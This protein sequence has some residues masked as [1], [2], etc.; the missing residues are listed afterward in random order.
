MIKSNCPFCGKLTKQHRNK[1]GKGYCNEKCHAEHTHQLFIE[2]WLR[3]D[4]E[5]TRGKKSTSAHIKRYIQERDG[6][7]CT[8]C[9]IG[10]IWN[11][12]P[13]TIEI[14]HIDGD[15]RNNRPENLRCICPNCHTQTANYGAR[16]M[17]NSTRDYS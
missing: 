5:G 11:G 12:K 15:Y 14:D 16:N 7:K 17:G 6:D 8:V 13:L 9:G 10:N 2:S 3:G 1:Q 4:K